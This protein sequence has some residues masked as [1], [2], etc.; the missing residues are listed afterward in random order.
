VLQNVVQ[1]EVVAAGVVAIH[2]VISTHDG[3]RMAVFE[4][5]LEGQQV[6]FT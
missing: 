4:R 5:Q 3:A 2:L 1:Q 6:G